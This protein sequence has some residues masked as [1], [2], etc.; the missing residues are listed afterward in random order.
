MKRLTKPKSRFYTLCVLLL[1]G[2]F[3]DSGLSVHNFSANAQI[4]S[5][6]RPEGRYRTLSPYCRELESKLAA[7]WVRG[8]Q[9]G[10][11]LPELNKKIRKQDR[12]FNKLQNR[13]DRMNCYENMF[14]FGRTLRRTKKCHAIDRKI[15]RAKRDL[16]QLND[17]RA[18]IKD[19]SRDGNRRQRIIKELARNDCGDQYRYEARRSSSNW[20]EDSGLGELFGGPRRRRA[21]PRDDFNGSIQPYATYRT[22]CVRLCDG[23]YFP[24]SFSTLPSN[25]PTDTDVCQNKC[26]APAELYVYRNPGGE[27][28][29]MITPD[30]RP[31]DSIENAWRYRKEYIKGCSCKETEFSEADIDAH[32]NPK[33]QASNSAASGKKAQNKRAPFTE[34]SKLGGAKSIEDLIR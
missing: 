21:R 24:V 29:Q 30:G 7:D 32:N 3:F 25:F 13:A 17:E 18:S 22:M 14:I 10:N 31:Y 12:L 6:E 5:T 9:S 8:N 27:I 16:A 26:A 4:Y 19:A 34:D 23:Y 1:I 15:R 28:E 11:L 33:K 2:L 20:L